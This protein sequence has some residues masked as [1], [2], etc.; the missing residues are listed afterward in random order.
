MLSEEF[1]RQTASK[2]KNH[3]QKIKR[4][5]FRI[6]QKSLL[7]AFSQLSPTKDLCQWV[8]QAQLLETEMNGIF[9]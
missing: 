5:A 8:E 4:K 7:L 9:F 2:T 1:Q 3:Y 6:F